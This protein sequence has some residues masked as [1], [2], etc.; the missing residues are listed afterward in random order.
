[1]INLKTKTFGVG[2]HKARVNGKITPAY[3]A[4]NNMLVRC[5]DE[6]YQ[7]KKPTYIGCSVCEEWHN[8]QN[9][10]GWY[11]I[12]HPQESSGYCLDK[13]LL[14][15]GN[16]KYG[17]D[18]C[19]FIPNEINCFITDSSAM[20]G[21]LMIGVTK[22]SDSKNFKAYCH[23]PFTGS[24]GYIRYFKNEVE[25]HLAWRSRKSHFAELLSNSA[26]NKNV[27]DGLNRYK[28]AL[29]GFII[30]KDGYNYV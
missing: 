4:W 3:N 5:Y 26:T 17:P 28:Q 27:K 11:Y 9:F 13:D 25:G 10:A 22:P 23:N 21:D 1:M 19:I 2:K 14:V 16:R 20:R 6:E 24:R 8:F 7:R 18:L 15:I 29:D 30:Y 12:N